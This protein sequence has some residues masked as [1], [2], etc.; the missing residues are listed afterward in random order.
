ML[1]A[2]LP[3]EFRI[4]LVA[5]N[6]RM[7][8]RYRLTERDLC[9]AGVDARIFATEDDATLWLGQREPFSSSRISP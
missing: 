3:A 5:G 8:A 9:M 7:E 6:P 1:L 4:A 2:G